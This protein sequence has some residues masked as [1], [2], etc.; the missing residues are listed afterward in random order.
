MDQSKLSQTPSTMLRTSAEFNSQNYDASPEPTFSSTNTKSKN[1]Q[2]Y[3]DDPNQINNLDVL[4][5]T[6]NIAKRKPF[7]VKP[8]K[9]PFWVQDPNI[10][11]KQAYIFEFFP[12]ETMTYEQKLNAVTR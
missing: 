10:L 12:V 6:I 9:I 2:L 1:D 3:V 8:K 7:M 4:A 5:P 11:F